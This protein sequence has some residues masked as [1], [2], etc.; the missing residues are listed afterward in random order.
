MEI[1]A[2]EDGLKAEGVEIVG[3][4]HSGVSDLGILCCKNT[5]GQSKLAH[6]RIDSPP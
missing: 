5:E 1:N 4:F 2:V 6:P 3:Q